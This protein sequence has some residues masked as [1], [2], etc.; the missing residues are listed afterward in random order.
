MEPL[1]IA[2]GQSTPKVVLDKENNKFE[3]SGYSLPENVMEFYSPVFSWLKE[4]KSQPNPKTELHMNL[5]YFNSASSKII[6]DILNVF[7]EIKFKGFEVEIFWHYMQMDDDMLA[8]GE[9]YESMIN[10][11]FNLVSYVQ[12]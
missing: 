6:L 5:V 2:G 9:E 10:V 7:E 8:A 4:Y 3:I 11:P 1:I 12:S